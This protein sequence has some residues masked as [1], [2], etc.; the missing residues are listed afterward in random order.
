MPTF[1]ISNICILY[2]V[3][4]LVIPMLGKDPPLTSVYLLKHKIFRSGEVFALNSAFSSLA[5]AVFR[6]KNRVTDL[7][8]TPFYT[9]ACGVVLS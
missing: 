5:K 8:H 7:S 6:S 9:G 2:T 4:H 3:L 1:P